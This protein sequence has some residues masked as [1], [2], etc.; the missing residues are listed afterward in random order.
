M[1]YTQRPS[2]TAC[3][4]FDLWTQRMGRRIRRGSKGIAL[5]RYHNMQYAVSEYRDYLDMCV[6]LGYDMGSSFVLYPKDL[7]QAHDQAARRVKAKADAQMRQDFKSAMRAISGHLDFEMDGMKF[8][9]PTTPEELAAEG[10]A[11]HHCVGSY[12]DRVARK[13][14]VILFLRQCEDLNKPFYT[15]EVRG[16]KIAQVRGMRNCD[17]TPEVKAF[18]DEWEREVLWVPA[19]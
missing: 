16:G 18:M 5:L 8:L 12:T 13:E 11:L 14:C 19:A 6:K 9:L 7:R 15:V 10:N 17:A 4:E 1:I 2:A 3:A